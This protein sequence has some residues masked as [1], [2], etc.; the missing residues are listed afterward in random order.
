MGAC[1][2]LRDPIEGILRAF[3]DLVFSAKVLYV[4]LSNFTAWRVATGATLAASRG[5]APVSAIHTEYSLVERAAERELLPMAERFGLGVLGYSP[6]GGGM[7][8][9]KYR[10]G[11]S[12]RAQSSIANFLHQEGDGNKASALDAVQAVASETT[13]TA[14]AV[15]IAWS[16]AKGVIPIIGP[17]TADQLAPNLA[18]AHFT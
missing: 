16:I 11:Q 12:G 18:A 3:D 15:A 17:R 8:T 7:L 6:I 5:W 9:G 14:D 13:A 10:G 2:R 4:G 1:S